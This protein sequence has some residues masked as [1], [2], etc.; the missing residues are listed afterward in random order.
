MER[1][2]RIYSKPIYETLHWRNKATLHVVVA[3]GA[4]GMAVLQLFQ[5]MYPQQPVTV[6]Y[7]RGNKAETDYSATL[8][9]V[10]GDGF[11]VF[12]HEMDALYA[13][14]QML[15]DCRMGTQFYVAGTE[16][17]IWSVCKLTKLQDV[18]DSEVMK[19]LS[20]S[21]ARPVYCVHCKATM[22]E[23]TTNIVACRSC[24]R[25]LF[26][27]DHFSRHLGAYMGLMI[28]AENPG[29]VPEVEEIYP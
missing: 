20:N 15:S 3:K 18:Q 28:D 21:L 6:F 11:R 2:Y 13:F 26:V 25:K 19:E 4:G 10:V 7:V 22:A 17:F 27:R 23:V 16:S 1:G 14:Y 5:Q 29:E 9:K 12:D 8:A 24:G